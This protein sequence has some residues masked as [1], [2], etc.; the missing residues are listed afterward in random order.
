MSSISSKNSY[1]FL[2]PQELEKMQGMLCPACGT[3]L[4]KTAKALPKVDTTIPTRA[5]FRKRRVMPIK[6]ETVAVRIV[7]H[8]KADHHF[9]FDCIKPYLDRS[10]LCPTCNKDCDDSAITP[11]HKRAVRF[12]KKL[13][14]S[15]AN[16][17]LLG[18]AHGSLSVAIGGVIGLLPTLISSYAQRAAPV[19]SELMKAA[20]TLTLLF[21]GAVFVRNGRKFGLDARLAPH[22][23]LLG[24][25]ITAVFDLDY[26]IGLT[27]G[28][29]P[30]SLATI[31]SCNF[32]RF[33]SY[34]TAFAIM[35]TTIIVD[36]LAKKIKQPTLSTS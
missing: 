20:L 32:R 14:D 26:P 34:A 25:L 13:P 9:H 2:Q 7:S 35:S 21:N 27:L 30:I 3:A 11:W 31:R 24:G 19:P 1:Y 15:S 29:G 36:I 28:I 23:S 18:L 10:N 8:T 6:I 12:L 17:V 33:E 16:N 4:C 5:R 22:M